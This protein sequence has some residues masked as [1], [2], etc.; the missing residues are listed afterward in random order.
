[1]DDGVKVI[2]FSAVIR[3]VFFFLQIVKIDSTNQAVSYSRHQG[4]RGGSVKLVTNLYILPSPRI[5]ALR[6]A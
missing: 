2:P 5:I 3:S 1:L 6:G 4:R